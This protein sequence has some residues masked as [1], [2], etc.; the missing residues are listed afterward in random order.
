MNTFKKSERL[1]DRK[2]TENLFLKGRSL[3]EEPFRWVY[4]EVDEERESCVKTQIVVPKRNII[5]AVNRNLIK[6]HIK[7][8]FRNNKSHLINNLEKKK[9]KINLSIIYQSNNIISSV[10]IEEKIKS[11]LIR[12]NSNL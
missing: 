1:C 5:K 8:A 6:R 12:L 4:L 11:S 2:S 9:I 3:V 7:E 10:V